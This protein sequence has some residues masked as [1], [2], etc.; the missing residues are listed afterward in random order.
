MNPSIQLQKRENAIENGDYYDY[1]DDN[2]IKTMHRTLTIEEEER[3]RTA[4]PPGIKPP[5]SM[6]QTIAEFIS[7]TNFPQLPVHL[8][9][10][11]TTLTPAPSTNRPSTNERPFS[12]PLNFVQPDQPFQVG[13]N[14]IVNSGGQSSSLRL[15]FENLP[16]LPLRDVFVGHIR[17][18]ENVSSTHKQQANNESSDFVS[19]L[20]PV[21]NDETSLKHADVM[22]KIELDL[23]QANP[24]FSTDIA[25][26]DST[27]PQLTSDTI[28]ATLSSTTVTKQTATPNSSLSDDSN[29]FQILS[30]PSNEF[31]IVDAASALNKD[32]SLASF[33]ET[34]DTSVSTDDKN[35]IIPTT[36]NLQMPTESS[37]RHITENNSRNASNV[38]PNAVLSFVDANI[39]DKFHVG[40]NIVRLK[41]KTNEI[42]T[43]THSPENFVKSSFKNSLLNPSIEMLKK[44]KLLET[45]ESP[46][47]FNVHQQS[48]ENELP[49]HKPAIHKN[50]NRKL[51][52]KKL[53]VHVTYETH[54]TTEQPTTIADDKSPV[55]Q[56]NTNF[57][58]TPAISFTTQPLPSLSEQTTTSQH[59][60]GYADGSDRSLQDKQ[61]SDKPVSERL[62]ADIESSFYSEAAPVEQS[63]EQ[64]ESVTT[65]VDQD[66]TFRIDVSKMRS[67]LDKYLPKPS[68]TLETSKDVTVGFSQEAFSEKQRN[69]LIDDI[70]S[71]IE[72]VQKFSESV[73]REMRQ[74]RLYGSFASS[75]RDP[76]SSVKVI[77]TTNKNP[78]QITS[79]ISSIGLAD[80]LQIKN[81]AVFV[82]LQRARIALATARFVRPDQLRKLHH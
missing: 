44:A 34:T 35:L 10:D 80:S 54:S 53:K 40:H 78:S 74:A 42:S 6:Q 1:Y 50:R 66:Q 59:S 20:R 45:S 52:K 11:T 81:G 39:Q 73:R 5:K 27:K 38:L 82:P 46:F 36:A 60:S 75:D 68:S 43:P 19:T 63:K 2:E 41:L 65:H 57:K 4:K 77:S 62:I 61:S 70:L 56:A 15:K 17:I 32:F 9:T 29:Q 71:A 23:L 47:P 69:K 12:G 8:R 31:E 67:I 33:V 28:T 7:T 3:K 14:V 64:L 79:G 25:V 37:E 16:S 49:P 51:N 55:N 24:S 18:A 21:I 76:S 22:N 48:S 30:V 58:I 26:N 13:R 72:S